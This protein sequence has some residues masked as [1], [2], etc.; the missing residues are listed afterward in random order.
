MM[1][2]EIKQRVRREL[3]PRQQI[4]QHVVVSVVVFIVSFILVFHIAHGGI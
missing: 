2:D 3:S 1:S 4:T